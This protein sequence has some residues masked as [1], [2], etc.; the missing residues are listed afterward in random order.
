MSWTKFY[1]NNII[2]YLSTC[3]TKNERVLHVGCRNTDYLEALQAS[4]GVGL[5]WTQRERENIENAKF[6]IFSSDN[7]GELEGPFD[8]II[9][10]DVLS[11]VEDIQSFLEKFEKLSHPRTRYIITTISRLWQPL[12]VLAGFLGFREKKEE[13]NW[14]G[15]LDLQNISHLANLQI[16]KSTRRL[17]IPVYGPLISAIA[18]KYLVHLPLFKHFAVCNVLIARPSMKRTAKNPSVSVVVPARNEEG[19]IENVIKR[20]PKLGHFTEII[21]VEGNSSDNTWKEIQRVAEVYGSQQRIQHVKQSGSGKG[22]AVRKGFSMAT[23]DIVTILDADLT[24]PRKN[25]INISMR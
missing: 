17:L 9:M 12:M 8:F 19:N 11:Q 16:I 22:D 15:F 3:V 20:M 14:V 5:T 18:N 4:R 2:Q 10:S 24:M 7:V 25:L 1:H 21:F 13:K 23:G 6:E